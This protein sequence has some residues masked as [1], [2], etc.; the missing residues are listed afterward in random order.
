MDC[1]ARQ[2]VGQR[3]RQEDAFEFTTLDGDG[4]YVLVIADGLGGHLCG[5]VA[6]SEAIRAFL[7]QMH[8]GLAAHP[9]GVELAL[10]FALMA[11]DQEL[12]CLQSALPNCAGMATTFVAAVV[13][14]HTLSFISVG[15]SRLMVVRE[16]ELLVRNERHGSGKR[17]SSCVGGALE[18]LEIRSGIELKG[19]DRLILATD[20]L[21]ALEEAPILELCSSEY[22]S[23]ESAVSAL[24]DAVV[25][26]GH[27]HQDNCTVM[28]A[29]LGP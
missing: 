17:V 21:E 13:R 8:Q 7:G 24:L 4:G 2:I 20:G 27:P 25:A 11:A 6:S 9:Q 1:Y 28:V 19:G 22:I 3:E 16:G 29:Q 14:D 10:K 23:M 5:D 26:V 12:R 15:D 18:Q